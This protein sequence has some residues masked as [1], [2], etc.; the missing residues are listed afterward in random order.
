MKQE[1]PNFKPRDVK[2]AKKSTVV[3]NGEIWQLFDSRDQQVYCGELYLYQPKSRY[4]KRIKKRR[5]P[6]ATLVRIQYP[7]GRPPATVQVEFAKAE[8][9][10]PK[11]FAAP[12]DRLGL[13]W[14]NVTRSAY[15]KVRFKTCDKKR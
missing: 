9:R 15:E 14:K 2:Q 7:L 8:Q 10:K 6:P 11:S 5:Q 12:V 4:I 3:D 1:R 13:R